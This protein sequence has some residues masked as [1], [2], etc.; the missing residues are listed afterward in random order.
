MTAEFL[1]AS[2]AGD[3][4]EAEQIIG[5]SLPESWP[6]HPSAAQRR[7]KQL[8]SDASVQP[9]LT[10]AI[11]LRTSR[12]MIGNIGFH[13]APGTDAILEAVSPGAAEFGYTVHA[14]FRRQG[15]AEEAARALMAW[16]RQAH[17]VTTFILS[18]GPD[19]APSQ[20]LAA[21]LGFVKIGEQIDEVD[22]LEEILQLVVPQPTP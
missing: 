1:R 2:L 9:W 15:Y 21:K 6:E 4:K 18:I 22:G 17:G 3:L 10:R 11:A 8:E 19:N 12:A 20:A 16:A 7:L 14:E 13:A 5:L